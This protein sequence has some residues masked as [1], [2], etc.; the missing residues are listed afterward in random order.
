MVQNESDGSKPS[1]SHDKPVLLIV[2]DVE[3]TNLAKRP[4]EFSF[5]IVL[6]PYGS[7]APTRQ[8]LNPAFLGRR[9]AVLFCTYRSAP[10]SFPILQ[11]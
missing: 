4:C 6:R 3:L 7:R 2:D 11:H 1:I 8:H 9:S 5:E 10:S